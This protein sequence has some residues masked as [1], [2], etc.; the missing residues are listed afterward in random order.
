M[1][2]T[3]P[4]PSG[5]APLRRKSVV[6]PALVAAAAATA[7]TARPTIVLVHGAFADSSSRDGVV[8]RLER[9][10][11]PV[12]GLANPPSGPWPG[13]PTRAR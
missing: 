4:L 10:G 9:E 7:R 12:L 5:R 8:A 3:R 1:T 11:Y 6:I 2:Y 13:A